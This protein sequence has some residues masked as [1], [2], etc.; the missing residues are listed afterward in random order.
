MFSYYFKH[1]Q[2]EGFPNFSSYA[3]DCK[4]YLNIF[5]VDLCLTVYYCM[6]LWCFSV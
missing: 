4:E 5:A 1:L 6:K 3:A 2:Q